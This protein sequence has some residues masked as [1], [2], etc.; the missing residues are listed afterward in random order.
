[1]SIQQ[2]RLQRFTHVILFIFLEVVAFT[3]VVNF[4]QHQKEIF[5]HSTAILSDNVVKRSAQVVDYLSLQQA[6]DD[7]LKENA[8]LLNE[9]INTPLG[10]VPNVDTSVFQYDVIPARVIKNSIASLRNTMTLDRGRISGIRSSMGVTSPKGIIG[11]ISNVSDKYATLLSLLHIDT[12]VSASVENENFFGTVSWNGRSY[13][14]LTLSG[15]PIHAD[16]SIGDRVLTNG[17]STIFPKGLPIGEIKSYDFSKD[18]AFYIIELTPSIDL[19]NIEHVY[20]LKD[21]F[22]EEINSLNLDE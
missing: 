18:G 4:N 7:L 5:Q 6:N 15:I 3:L 19:S 16:I 8:R 14:S 20:I 22:A 2:T 9:I 11:I 17:Y 13:N 21:N 1:M 12:R 10:D